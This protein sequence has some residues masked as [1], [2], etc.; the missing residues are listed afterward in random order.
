MVGDMFFHI[1]LK[2]NKTLKL[3]IQDDLNY[4]NVARKKKG[5]KIMKINVDRFQSRD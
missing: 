2:K 5:H 4:I 3:Y 1:Y